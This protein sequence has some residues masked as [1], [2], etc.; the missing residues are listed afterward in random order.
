[1]TTLSTSK[2]NETAQG[3]E[4]SFATA[5]L[6]GIVGDL[7]HKKRGGFHIS[8]E[9]QPPTNYSVIRQDDKAPPG[10]WPRDRAAAIDMSMGESDIILCHKRLRA[11][12]LN[13]AN[14]PRAKFINA[15]NGWDGNGDAGRYDM[16]T[17]SVQNATS[18]H[19][20]HIHMEIR[21]RYVNSAEM[22]KAVLSIVRGESLAT[23][24]GED[25]AL[26][27]T[28]KTW[29]EN[30]IESKVKAI[31]GEQ[32]ITAPTG[33]TTETGKISPMDLLT[34]AYLRANGSLNTV[35][36]LNTAFTTY[37]VDEVQRDT[38]E[39]ARD[40]ALLAAVQGVAGG[41]TLSP[42]QFNELK[43]TV[44]QAAEEAG[45]QAGEQANQKITKLVNAL[46]A[47]GEDLATADDV[48]SGGQQ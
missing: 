11:V 22:V 3:W 25:V 21:R 16:V 6:S 7:E 15:W 34:R 37:V 17:G 36:G 43:E 12:W 19:K 4:N 44:R 13:R 18:D 9:D 28:D 38:Q 33:A 8:I 1:M 31:W 46:A 40:A 10:D 47:A 14:D 41:T 45:Q 48:P 42:T 26:D 39:K 2:L 24:L 32:F 30:T 29:F 5:V 35:S 20:W 23:Y 27:N